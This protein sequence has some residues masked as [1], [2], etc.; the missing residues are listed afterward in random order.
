MVVDS[1]RSA[2]T[3]RT[4]DFEVTPSG[5]YAAFPS[6]LPLTGYD[7]AGHREV[8]RY[9]SANEAIDCA[10]CNSTG[11]L[12]TGE[13]GL[14][15]NGLSLTNDGRVF[16]NA[17]EGLVDRDLNEKQD[18]YE[19]EKAPGE[20]EGKDQLISSGTSILA[21]SLLGVSANGVDAYFFTHETLASG[22]RNGG[23]VKLYDAR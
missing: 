18:A 13:A 21:S 2:A 9:D 6:A 20:T 19:W 10:S 7:N 22:D 23:R 3:R 11:E 17:D 14:A 12:A 4:A 8:F 15:P 1:L 16:F 5:S